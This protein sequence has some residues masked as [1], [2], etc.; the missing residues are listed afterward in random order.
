MPFS[1]LDVT[2]ACEEPNSKL[3]DV[4]VDVDVDVGVDVGVATPK[5]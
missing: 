1:R 3:V 2:L 4:D 5:T